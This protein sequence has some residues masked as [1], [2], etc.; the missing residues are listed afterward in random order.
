MHF[1]WCF[2]HTIAVEN[3]FMDMKIITWSKLKMRGTSHTWI[4]EFSTALVTMV[5]FRWIEK[6]SFFLF[7]AVI[8]IDDYL[9]TCTIIH[10]ILIIKEKFRWIYKQWNAVLIGV[11][12]RL[13]QEKYTLTNSHGICILLHTLAIFPCCLLLAFD[14]K[15]WFT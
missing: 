14:S 12:D 11:S 4:S 1:H 15:K 8:D 13:L 10:F 6:W 7:N 9:N 2:S 5:T 3:H